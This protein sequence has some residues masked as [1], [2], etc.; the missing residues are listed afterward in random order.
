MIERLVKLHFEEEN[1]LKF[2]E[3]FESSRAT[4][5]AWPGCVSLQA[6]RSISEAGVYFTFSR[7]IDEDALNNYRRSDF[8]GQTWAE[9]KALF[10]AAP[11][12]WSSVQLKE[13][14]PLAPD[15]QRLA[16]DDYHIDIGSLD[17][18]QFAWLKSKD[19]SAFFIVV[20]DNTHQHCW[21]IFEEVLKKE[22]GG[23][24]LI[25]I[26]AGELFKTLDTTQSIWK[27]LFD[28]NA[29]RSVCVINLG[30]GVVGDMGGFA[31]SAYK[32]GVDF[33]QVP[34]T[35]LSQVDASVGG[36][37]GID[38]NGLKNSIGVFRDPVAVWIDPVFLK[39]LSDRELRSG[40]AEVIKHAL[41]A[42]ADQWNDLR[43]WGNI[44]EVDWQRVIPKS[45][46]IKQRIVTLDPKEAHLR[47]SL[48][49]G[50]TI[51]HALESYWLDTENRLLHGEAI[52]A[53]M[54][55][56]AWLSH[57]LL[58]LPAADLD[59]IAG[60]LVSIYG[61]QAIPESTFEEL[62]KTMRQDKKNEGAEV[63]CSLLEKVGQY[64]V[65]MLVEARDL[66][67]SLSYYNS[68]M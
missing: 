13:V 8:F 18:S 58:D 30:G 37:L 11:E 63:N 40:F 54:I 43:Q 61:H 16:L 12:A 45:I 41:I 6:W 7:W 10:K 39:T 23:Y 64:R 1:V 46:S 29:G 22:I 28:K 2:E 56:E 65:N 49:F 66:L 38:F 57:K 44:S 27:E 42:D 26:A 51:G 5:S 55:C 15:H 53:G 25:K 52:A 24:H 4:I 17:A 20:D 50:H 3:I 62:L 21:P 36:K 19:Y 32:R 33:V 60:Y 67:E 14:A 48:N 59:Q 35:L 9:T 68:L 34:T 31:A 47:K